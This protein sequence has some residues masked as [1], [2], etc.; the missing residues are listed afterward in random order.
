LDG[1]LDIIVNNAGIQFTAPTEKFPTDKYKAIMGV[2][3]DAPF[4]ISRAALPQMYER[5]WGRLIHIGSAHSHV[6]SPNKSAYCAAK[7]GVLGLSR[8]IALEA[9]GRG[10]TSNTICPGWVHTPLVKKQIER[11]SS[12]RGISLDEAQKVLTLDKHP[13]NE[14]VEPE[15]LGNFAVYLST[16]AAGQ[17]NGAALSMDLGWTVR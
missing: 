14:F 16:D 11:I 15:N 1:K 5:G 7:H 6:A 4:Y 13:T 10:V 12:E 8:A 17:I 3:V 9:A 2:C